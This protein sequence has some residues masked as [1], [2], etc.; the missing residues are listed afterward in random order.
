MMGDLRLD[1]PA[2]APLDRIV[3]HVDA[4]GTR[5]GVL[6]SLWAGLVRR[7]ARNLAP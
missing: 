1:S 5:A 3:P 7:W 6:E 4:V 2:R